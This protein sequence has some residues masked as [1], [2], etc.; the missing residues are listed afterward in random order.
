MSL[1]DG[2]RGEDREDPAG[3]DVAQVCAVGVPERAEIHD[4]EPSPCKCRTDLI[5]ED[6]R[7][8]RHQVDG[9]GP[10]RLQLLGW[11]EPVGRPGAE[12]RRDLVLEAGDAHLEE[13]VEPLGEDRQELDALGER[14]PLVRRQVEQTRTE[15]QP[16]QFAVD[17][18]VRRPALRR[19]GSSLR[20]VLRAEDRGPP[21][22]VDRLPCDP[23]PCGR[24]SVGEGCR[25]LGGSH[26][27]AM[28]S[29]L[30]RRDPTRPRPAPPRIRRACPPTRRT[31]PPNRRGAGKMAG[32]PHSVAGKAL[33]P[34]GVQS[35]TGA[36]DG[37]SVQ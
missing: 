35:Q 27:A 5:R 13:F 21:R 23:G 28:V 24:A 20:L 16:G 14:D 30:T 3:E 4:L 33:G 37:R 22:A 9:A 10:D 32:P 19:R 36:H 7:G 31:C 6:P 29:P 26:R 12:P 1:I 8:T 18:P 2:E 15:G 17:E 25:P 34:H 11:A